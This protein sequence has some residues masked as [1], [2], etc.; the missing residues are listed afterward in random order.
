MSN[1]AVAVVMSV[2]KNDISSQL[3]SA[4]ESILNQTL[5]SISLYI[6]IDGVIDNEM[7]KLLDYYA[8][9]ERV[10]IISSPTNRGLAVSLNHLVDIVIAEGKFEYIAR[11][12]SDDISLPE[13]LMVQ[14]EYLKQN[15]DVD[16]LG[17]YC[18][19][20]GASFALNVKKV[21]L[22]HDELVKYSLY[23]CPFIHPTVMFRKRVFQDGNRYPLDTC[24]SE[25]LALWF[26]LLVRGYKFSNVDKVLINYRINSDT[27][28]RRS[29]LNKAL[30]EV[31]LRIKYSLLLKN[32]SLKIYSL[33]VARG[34]F[35][36]MP[37]P[38]KKMMYSKLR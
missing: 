17:G 4:I 31:K 33:I 12:D 20:F 28:H 8:V 7:S 16:V 38:I 19:E 23:K 11:M 13:R 15:P 32:R 37:H 2:Y 24:F 10:F 27:L 29:G 26:L 22:T 1:E 35:S 6:M 30:S 34:F 14:V 18:H 5:E 21:P 36:L 25:D 9:D 3:K